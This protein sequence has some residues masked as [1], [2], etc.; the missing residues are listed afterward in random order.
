M[1]LGQ[2]GQVKSL[3]L[4]S[5]ESQG[6]PMAVALRNSARL[7]N[8]PLAQTFQSPAGKRRRPEKPTPSHI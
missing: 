2:G 4:I 7:K 1:S 6:W 8:D 3:S 5:P